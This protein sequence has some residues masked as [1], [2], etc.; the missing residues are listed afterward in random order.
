MD[1]ADGTAFG[2]SVS[3]TFR[4]PGTH[5]ATVV[6]T[7]DEGDTA[8]DEVTITVGEPESEPP[9]IVEAAADRTS[10]VAPLDVLFH[11]VAE[12][13]EGGRLTYAWDFGDGGAAFGDEAEH[14]YLMPGSFTAT[15]T[16]TDE[17]G[18]SAS[19]EIVIT[20]SDP[21]GNRAPSVEGAAL[22]ASGKAPLDVRL[23]AQGSDPDGDTLT[24]AWEFGDGSAP[25]SGRT[26]RHV[27][28][29]NGVFT[30]RVTVTDRAGL[31]GTDE[32]AITVGDPAGGQAPTVQAAADPGSG[33][34]PLK[35]NFSAA[36]SD[37]DGDAITYVWDFGDGG[38]AGGTHVSHTYATPGTYAAKVTVTDVGGKTG[39]ATV[40]VT[41]S[42]AV[43]A[44]R[45]AR[46]R[47]GLAKGALRAVSV[48]SLAA[49]RARGLK[50]A[51]T[52]AASGRAA[53]GLWASRK[54]ARRLALKS[55]GLGR[56]QFDCTAGKTLQLTI[57]PSRKVRKAIRIAR[58]KSL[59]LTVALALEGGAP[60]TRTLNLKRV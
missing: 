27:Y 49:F 40:M 9:V 37:P 4:T 59:K 8:T 2:S 38:Q 6:V 54:A 13:P 23:T 24:Y 7:D 16:V 18:E 14:T 32:V 41:V 34:A 48:P 47:A 21:P 3:H 15:V 46:R 1:V 43:Q 35:V 10:G 53:V 5:T 60:L 57:R 50:V 44:G 19:E 28:V 17:T 39:T 45:R 52:C 51:A 12:D 26:A 29:R 36:G 22:P 58:P 31:T 11:V 20:V 55:R 30:A 25:V 42:G 33:A 56:S